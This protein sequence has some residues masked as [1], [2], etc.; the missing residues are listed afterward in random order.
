MKNFDKLIELLDSE[1]S[2]PA[3]Y[4]FKFIV[5]LDQVSVLK[6]LIPAGKMEQKTSRTGKYM[7]VTITTLINETQEVINLYKKVQHIP[8]IISL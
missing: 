7:S 6:A 4:T 1:Y 3:E 5:S 2:W 8:G